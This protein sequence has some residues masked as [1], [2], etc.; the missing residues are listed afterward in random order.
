VPAAFGRI[1]LTATGVIVEDSLTFSELDLERSILRSSFYAFVQRMWHTVVPEKPVWNWHIEFL[2]NELQLMCERIFRG[3]PS[4]YDWAGNVPPGTSKSTV[5]SIFLLPWGWSRMPSFRFL[6]YSYSGRLAA[7]LG[8]KSRDCV[9]SEDYQR[10]FPEIKLKDDVDAKFYFA[11]TRGGVRYAV[12]TGGTVV[13]FH[14]HFILGDDPLNPNDAVSEAKLAAANHFLTQVVP[15]RKVDLSLVPNALIMQRLRQGDPTEMLA[16]TSEECRVI[17]IPATLEYEVYPEYLK[18]RYVDGLMDPVRLNQQALANAHKRLGDYGFASQYGQCLVAGTLVSTDRGQVPIERIVPGDRVWTREGLR[19]VYWSGKTKDADEIASVLFSDGSMVCG[20]PDHPVWTENR[21]W[22]SLRDLESVD[23]VLSNAL[24]ALGT[25]LWAVPEIQTPKSLS[26]T[27]GRTCEAPKEPTS[28]VGRG[29]TGISTET[30]GLST[31][32]LFPRATTYTT[33]TKT[34]ATTT[35][36]I[37][38]VPPNV[39]TACFTPTGLRLVESF[40]RRS[41]NSA[42]LGTVLRPDKSIIENT[43]ECVYERSGRTLRFDLTYAV[44]AE[45]GSSPNTST[46]PKCS[47]AP[48]SAT[49]GVGSE[50]TTKSASG[51]ERISPPARTETTPAPDLVGLGFGVPVYDLAVERTHEFFANGVLVHNSPIPAQGGMFKTSKLQYG[52]PPET[53]RR[54][55]R[56]WDKAVTRVTPGTKNKGAAYTAGVKMGLGSDGRIWVLDVQRFQLDSWS[57]D[58]KIRQIAVR[59]SRFCFVGI[60]Q[61]PGSG[62]EDA[63][64][65]TY[66]RI[67]PLG[68]GGGFKVKSFRPTGTKEDRADPFSCHVNSGH[69]WIN[70]LVDGRG[71]PVASWAKDYVEEMKYW[72]FSTHLDQIDASAHAYNFLTRA[73]RVAGAGF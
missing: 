48:T 2:C 67:N 4:A 66:R 1:P 51:A 11:N 45:P 14:F 21:G 47:S 59:D 72:P 12:G 16:E 65:A 44:S 3:E 20:T 34:H 61:E 56:V 10:L 71:S 57:R 29:E 38:C 52:T 13:G 50:S 18:E 24:S 22:T 63:F 19:S 64:Q 73:R 55:I 62:G 46:R 68:G 42:N 17:K 35:L 7:D 33:R 69:V 37:W 31:T 32:A 43:A 5:A 36:K 60:E 39:S 8:R 40:L 15:S 58:T 26:S 30:F 54:I 53:F 25:D 23:C 70:S 28:G 9:L 41:V 49:S 27:A 6:G